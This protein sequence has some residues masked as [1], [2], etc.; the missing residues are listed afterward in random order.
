ME[1]GDKLEAGNSY[2]L[3][4]NIP[5]DRWYLAGLTYAGLT[6][7][8]DWVGILLWLYEVHMPLPLCTF[9]TILWLES[10]LGPGT[11][12]VQFLMVGL[13]LQWPLFPQNAPRCDTCGL[14]EEMTDL[15]IRCRRWLSGCSNHLHG[16]C[17]GDQGECRDCRQEPDPLQDKGE[18]RNATRMK[19]W[20]G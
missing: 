8:R 15:L 5:R 9:T 16:K 20:G 19:S 1:F 12:Y 17:G 10:L 2:T 3:L 11:G 14:P 7:Q 4:K 18:D 6:D 13:A